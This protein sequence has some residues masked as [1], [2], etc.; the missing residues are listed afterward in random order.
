MACFCPTKIKVL[1]H[2]GVALGLMAGASSA[3]ADCAGLDKKVRSAIA[4]G[5]RTQF[6]SLLRQIM[7]E[8]TCSSEY[9]SKTP[10]VLAL[11]SVKS[12]VREAQASGTEP[13]A[14]DLE[15]AAK[16]SPVWQVMVMLGD[17]YY[18]KKDYN[19]AFRAYEG[20]LDDMRNVALNPKLPPEAMERHAY[21]RAIQ[22]RALAPKFLASKTTRGKPGGLAVRKFRNFTAVAVPVPVKFEFDRAELNEQGL[23]AAK[24]ILDAILSEG[25][26]SVRLIGHTDP[27]GSDDYNLQLSVARAQAV[28]QY[29]TQNGYHGKVDVVGMGESQP[30]KADDP[31][32][33]SQDELYSMYR[34]V[35]YQVIQ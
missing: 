24:E 27:K 26:T 25:A 17:V 19:K 33:Y 7:E 3:M 18:D 8:P 21:N 9:R 31:G 2:A 11:S 5:D 30:F 4:S 15:Q 28:A 13:G 32:K 35:E 34:R 22:A 23:L 12:I 29:L 6:G 20:A 16:I 10:R 1:L 14:G